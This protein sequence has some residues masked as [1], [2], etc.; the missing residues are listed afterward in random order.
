MNVARGR[1]AVLWSL[2]GAAAVVAAL[3]APAYDLVLEELAIR[4][5]DP[6][7]EEWRRRSSSALRISLVSMAAM[8]SARS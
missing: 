8:R 7:E 4:R 1:R 6:G 2:V 5:L 3:A